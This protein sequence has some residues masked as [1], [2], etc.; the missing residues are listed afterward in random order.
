MCIC[1]TRVCVRE[2]APPMKTYIIE[3]TGDTS[4]T[5]TRGSVSVGY[6][7]FE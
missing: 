5:G 2:G 1:V 4:N 7:P 6:V 3:Q